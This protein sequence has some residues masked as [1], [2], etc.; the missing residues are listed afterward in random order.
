[1]ERITKK[2]FQ[3]ILDAWDTDVRGNELNKIIDGHWSDRRGQVK[4]LYGSWLRSS[5]KDKFDCEYLDF[6]AGRAYE[7]LKKYL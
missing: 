1:M 5:D 4:R 7:D 3:E 2:K 6:L